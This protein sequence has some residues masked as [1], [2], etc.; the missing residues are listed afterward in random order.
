MSKTNIIPAGYRFTFDSYEGDGN[1]LKTI[2]KQGVSENEAH[3]L[4]KIANLMLSSGIWLENQSDPTEKE[5]SKAYKMLWPIFEAH[6]D[7]FDNET[8]ELFKE[9]VDSM[10]DYI[11][12]NIVDY[13]EDEY[14]MRVLKSYHVEYTP[15]AIELKD[16][17]VE[18]SKLN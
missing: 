12:E 4:A 5:K 14:Y 18:F 11:C 16:V 15:V 17:T 10:A 6:K 7:I 8:L 13:A 3:L 9:G 1:N 2:V